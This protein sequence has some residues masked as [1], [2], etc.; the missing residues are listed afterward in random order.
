MNIIDENIFKLNFVIKN[1][2]ITEYENDLFIIIS[3]LIN[4]NNIFISSKINIFNILINFIFLIEFFIILIII[5]QVPT[6]CQISKTP[7][8][9]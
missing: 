9:F 8:K 6:N 2:D 3:I 1:L 5:E 4:I 7:T